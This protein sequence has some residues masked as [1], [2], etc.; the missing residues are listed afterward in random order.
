MDL[1]AMIDQ[2]EQKNTPEIKEDSEGNYE[3]KLEEIQ[4]QIKILEGLKS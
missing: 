2:L 1:K 3:D 4:K